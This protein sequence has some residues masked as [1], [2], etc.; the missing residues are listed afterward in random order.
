MEGPLDDY[1]RLTP[2]EE[3]AANR[4]AALVLRRLVESGSVEQVIRNV[5]RALAESPMDDATPHSGDD[6][7]LA[8]L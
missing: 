8:V 2:S 1:P 4:D 3:L 7:A 5:A 6:F